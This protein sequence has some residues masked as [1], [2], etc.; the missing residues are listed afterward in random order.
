MT[1][2]C[3]KILQVVKQTVMTSV[4]GVTFVGARKQIQNILEER[5]TAGEGVSGALLSFACLEGVCAFFILSS[6]LLTTRYILGMLF[7]IWLLYL[8]HVVLVACARNCGTR[9]FFLSNTKALILSNKR[10]CQGLFPCRS[11]YTW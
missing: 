2:Q 3:L 7:A 4:Y 9:L 1:T 5:M 6:L 10:F 8:G 11:I